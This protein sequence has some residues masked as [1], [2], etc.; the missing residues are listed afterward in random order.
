MGMSDTRSSR[1]INAEI[2]S[3]NVLIWE[4]K[5][6]SQTLKRKNQ[7]KEAQIE[8][9]IER[10]ERKAGSG[11]EGDRK[12][13]GTL[14]EKESAKA[15]KLR[16]S[17]REEEAPLEEKIESLEAKVFWLNR[18]SDSAFKAEQEQAENAVNTGRQNSR[19]EQLQR[20]SVNTSLI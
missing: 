19:M 14:Q 6:K 9:E 7:A 4:A 12:K 2:A 15:E 20:L 17:N 1:S 13:Y 16:N 8:D 5:G 11:F 3:L 10:L 18:E